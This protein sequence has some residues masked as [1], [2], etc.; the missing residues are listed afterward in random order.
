[1][2]SNTPFLWERRRGFLHAIRQFVAG[3]NATL[4]GVVLPKDFNKSRQRELGGAMSKETQ[5]SPDRLDWDIR[6]AD[7][8]QLARLMPPAPERN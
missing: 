4:I 3:I 5:R 1:M 7:A 6:V 2:R 8:L